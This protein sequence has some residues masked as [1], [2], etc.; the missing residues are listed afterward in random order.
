MLY[1]QQEKQ[2]H[3]PF[4]FFRSLSKIA[5]KFNLGTSFSDLSCIDNIFIC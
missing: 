5:I 1:E 4:F 2:A 3:E